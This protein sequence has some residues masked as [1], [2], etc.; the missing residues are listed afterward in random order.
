[1]NTDA[2]RDLTQPESSPKMLRRKLIA[3]VAT[4][5]LALGM[6]AVTAT[7]ASAHHNTITAT[8]SC[9]TD[10]KYQIDWSVTNSE[11]NKTETITAS[12]RT[13]AV[14]VGSTL[15]LSETKIFPE[16]VT[17]PINATL[18]LTG[19]WTLPGTTDV[20][21][22]NSGSVTKGSFPDCD[23]Q[24]VPVTLCHATPPA[25]GANGWVAITVDDD[26]VVTGPGHNSH[27][28]DI[29]PAFMYWAKVSGV[30]TQ[31]SYPGKNLGTVFSGFT[32]AQIAA[33]G[34]APT[35]TAAA[36]TFTPAV[37][38][39]AG[40]AGDGSYTIPATVGVQYSV[41][42]NGSGPY[43][44]V[45]AGTVSVPIG[46][47][48]QVKAVGLPSWVSLTGTHEWSYTWVSPG[49]CIVTVAPVAPSAAAISECGTYGSITLPT[50]T[51]VVYELTSGDGMQGVWEV[52]ATPAAGYKFDGAQSVTFGGNLGYY[53]ECVSPAPPT[54]TDAEC[55]GPGEYS[56]GSYTIPSTEGVTYQVKI[57]DEAWV[58]VA[59]GTYPVSVF[60][61]TV[62]IKAIADDDY[63][64]EDYDGPW[65]HTFESAGTCLVSSSPVEPTVTSISECGMYG[66]VTFD[67]TIG[68][69]YEFTVGDGTH[70][71]WEVTA[72]PAEGYRFDGEQQSVTFS[73]DLGK[74]TK[75]VTAVEATFADSEC[76][77]GIVTSGT[78]TIPDVEGVQY[79]VKINDA[80]FTDYSAGTY[81]AAD[82]DVVV[83]QATELAGYTLTGDTEWSHT[84]AD[85]GECDI[86]TLGLAV[87]SVSSAPIT[88]SVAGSYTVGAEINGE[89]VVWTLEGSDTPIPFGTYPVATAQVI[90]LVAS[91]N[92]P[93]H[94]GLADI[95][96]NEWINPTVLKFVAP[97]T[98][99][100]G[101][102]TTLALTGSGGSMLGIGLAG[103]LLFLGVAGIYMR[104]R[105]G[106]NTK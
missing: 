85:V 93:V 4:L 71:L 81:D 102:L 40:V 39:A 17:D 58:E 44:D 91:S 31:L 5:A 98:A 18:T 103:G 60:P 15:G 96:S 105:Y 2:S 21:T 76:V 66:S 32:G 9:T 106:V 20:T 35:V 95:D 46:T 47:S 72:T 33:A 11:S 19:K 75:C 43:S 57:G 84:F 34:C 30:W 83:I 3:G 54:F 62:Q 37:C 41:R 63:T 23:P 12:N 13:A 61:T 100:C 70:G 1:M 53:T 86:P 49:D 79:I 29:I 36:P 7:S 82:G 16:I 27:D 99:Q 78:F 97:S 69:V 6:V 90:T 89:H 73:G 101:K 38:T 14:S 65:S 88:C 87:P 48:I 94:F 22:T 45:S 68:V 55:T 26:A 80:G 52:T 56:D 51:G 59:A 42:L 50:T 77:L 104:R 28:A 67:D 8:V 64:L 10:Y 74:Y 25:T 24:H 92:D